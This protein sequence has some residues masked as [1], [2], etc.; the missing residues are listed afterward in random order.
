[1]QATLEGVRYILSSE[2]D[3]DPIKN[4]LGLK[5]LTLVCS[6][7]QSSRIRGS[8]CRWLPRPTTI[9]SATLTNGT[10][11]VLQHLDDDMDKLEILNYLQKN[12][13]AAN[14]I[15]DLLGA[16]RGHSDRVAV[17]EIAE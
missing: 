11:V 14:H 12:A 9:Q 6:T 8:L 1:M 4:P 3:N 17:R 10:S 13:R 15:I 7:R 5:P 16:L 2:Y